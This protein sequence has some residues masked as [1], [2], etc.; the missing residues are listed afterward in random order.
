MRPAAVTLRGYPVQLGIAVAEHI[1]EW[2]R[3]FQLIA[4]SRAAGSDGG[5][6]P[7]RL[8]QMISQLSRTYGTELEGPD[9]LREEAAQRGEASVDLTYPVRPETEQVVRAWQ[10]LLR[11]VD[12]YC[13]RE[14]LL[15][16]QRPPDQVA[17]QDWVVEE[18]LRQ[19]DGEPPR[20]WS[21]AVHVP[22]AV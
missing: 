19:L 10:Q 7:D 6:V 8:V 13:A 22:R 5:D 12:E 14:D 18:F 16:L 2:M 17:L 11:E 3:E 1:E 4:L 21:G 20:P 15:T 9:R